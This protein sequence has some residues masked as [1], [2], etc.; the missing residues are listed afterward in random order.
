NKRISLGLGSVSAIVAIVIL[1]SVGGAR[2]LYHP[3]QHLH[4]RLNEQKAS[5]PGT[6][7][8]QMLELFFL[9]T[10][11][12]NHDLQYQLREQEQ[13]QKDYFLQQMLWGTLSEK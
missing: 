2:R 3:I 1:I 12:K 10:M 11:N 13:V 6:D 8:L 4:N 7:G 5:K 9:E